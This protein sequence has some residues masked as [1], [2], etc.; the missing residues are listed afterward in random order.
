MPA[1][2]LQGMIDVVEAAS[3]VFGDAAGEVPL[4]DL[5]AVAERLRAWSFSARS[6][7]ERQLLVSWLNIASGATP[8]DRRFPTTDGWRSALELLTA[9]EAVWSDPDSSS[10]DLYRATW[11]LGWI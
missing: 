11:P 9:A 1:E 10:W 3:S 8:L 5:D 4:H 2:D 7:L 6:R